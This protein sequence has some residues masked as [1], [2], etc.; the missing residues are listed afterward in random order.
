MSGESS[1]PSRAAK[2][3]TDRA[4]ADLLSSD[5]LAAIVDSPPGAGKSTFVVHAAAELA[6]Q[7]DQVPIVAQT[8]AQADDLVRA[9][10]RQP[11][12]LQIGRLTG[13][14]G[15]SGLIPTND[16]LI[17]SKIDDLADC[18][19]VV[20]T[21]AKWAYT[22][23]S[24]WP[25]D[26]GIIDEAYQMRSDQLLYVGQIF[27]RVLMVGDPG[28]LDPFSPIDDARWRGYADGPINPAVATVLHNHPTSPVHRLPI[29][30]RLPELCAP[31]VSEAFY[32]TMPFDA[33][34]TSSDRRIAV[35]GS[36]GTDV[37][38]AIELAADSG[39]S[40]LELPERVAPPTDREAVEAVAEVV[41]R[42]LELDVSI[43]D[44]T[45]DPENAA[46]GAD[47][48]AVGVVLATNGR[49]FDW[50]S[51][52]RRP[53]SASTPQPSLSTLRIGCKAA[54]RR[55]R[56]RAPPAVRAGIRI[57]VPS[58]DGQ[59]LRCCSLVTVKPASWS[60]GQAFPTCSTRTPA[61]RR[62]GSVPP[63]R[64]LTDGKRTRS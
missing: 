48:V 28:Q 63:S 1:E 36:S 5:H 3:V 38:K 6:K 25:Y 55:C 15:G 26:A 13:S 33:G 14:S 39:W 10:L 18:H 41:V 42:L 51:I 17:E 9:L 64:S 29:S 61:T 50:S 4:A 12:G 57:G 62:F 37:D 40:F 47:Q 16:L 22:A 44:S 24:I 19:V 53:V 52:V 31:L 30:W 59:T 23:N 60:D 45:R 11:G 58:R 56:R 8:N 35:T 43:Y 34:T 2:R 32:P 7:Q 49:R 20:G 21:A 27:E 54:S 46:L